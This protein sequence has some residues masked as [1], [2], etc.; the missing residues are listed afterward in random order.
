MV[1]KL[2]EHLLDKPSIESEWCCVCGAP[3]LNQHHVIVKGMGG[4]KLE[5]RI[6]TVSLCGMG[7]TGGC[8]GKAHSGR[9]FFDYRD[10]RWMFF[11]STEPITL[12]DAMGRD[13]WRDCING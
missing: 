6:P 1:N 8:H 2:N 12:L 11:E 13:G 7:N 3:S 9:L 5:K 10:G 4:S